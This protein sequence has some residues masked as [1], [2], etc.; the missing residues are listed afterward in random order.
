VDFIIFMERYFTRIENTLKR[1]A[2]G[3]AVPAGSREETVAFKFNSERTVMISAQ[4]DMQE[5]ACYSP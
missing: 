2:V 5:V 1:V 4:N 3:H